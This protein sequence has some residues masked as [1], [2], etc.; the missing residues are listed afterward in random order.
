MSI[1]FYISTALRSLTDKKKK[2]NLFEITCML[3]LCDKLSQSQRI[4][5]YFDFKVHIL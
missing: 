5:N 2:K 1:N 4:Y 3:F